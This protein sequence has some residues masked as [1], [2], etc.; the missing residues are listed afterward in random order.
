MKKLICWALALA[1]VVAYALPV[2][3]V[4]AEPGEGTPAPTVVNTAAELMEAIEEAEDGDTIYIGDAIKF[5]GDITI[6]TEEKHINLTCHESFRHGYLFSC[7][8]D[9]AITVQNITIDGNGIQAT[10]ISSHANELYLKNVCIRNHRA[11]ALNVQEGKLIIEDCRFEDNT[12]GA[13]SH[14]FLQRSTTAVISGTSFVRGSAYASCG[15]AISSYADVV[16]ENCLFTENRS[17]DGGGAICILGGKCEVKATT[18]ANNETLN[19]GSSGGDGGG[20]YNS[21]TL[22]LSNTQIYGNTAQ[23][24][25][26]DIFSKGTLNIFVTSDNLAEIYQEENRMPLGFYT[27]F[28]DTRFNGETNVTELRP[29]P[30]SKE[31]GDVAALIFIFEDDISAQD[32]E[33]MEGPQEPEEPQE[34][35]SEDDQSGDDEPSEE[36]PA[37][38]QEQEPGEPQNPQGPDDGED[39]SGD[40]ELPE[41]ESTAPSQEQQEKPN[42]PA[43]ADSSPHKPAPGGSYTPPSDGGNNQ[44]LEMIPESELP[45]LICGGA[46]LDTSNRAYL[47]GYGDGV[48]GEDDPITRAQ[49]AQI[50][51][52]LLS[53]ESREAL[54]TTKNSFEDVP[55]SAWYNLPISTIARAGIVVGYGDSFHPQDY[56]TRA[57][58]ITILA[59]FIA[60]VDRESSFADIPGHWAEASVST[61]EAAGWLDGSGDLRPDEYVMRGEVVSFINHVFDLCEKTE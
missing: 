40:K 60:P 18:I 58:L 24:C 7:S 57:Q 13:G 30:I 6:G 23:Q 12:S 44:E 32:N 8:T 3:A 31:N 56:L 61:A 49:I 55:A 59:R 47:V 2:A 51:Y 28:T 53:E 15:G 45:A 29:L 16:I 41:E 10:A 46:V 39:R 20:I 1:M 50:I 17:Y 48:I 36:D 37:T 33:D 27:D 14:L 22:I 9:A 43:T 35:D 5:L 42:G 26:A 54:E 19:I 4:D 11:G 21:G 25:G 34:P 52:R 38:P